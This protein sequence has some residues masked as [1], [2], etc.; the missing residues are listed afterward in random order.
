VPDGEVAVTPGA[1]PI[2]QDGET[3]REECEGRGAGEVQGYRGTGEDGG[4]GPGAIMSGGGGVMCGRVAVG[5]EEEVDGREER[6]VSVV[7]TGDDSGDGS[8]ERLAA[9][10]LGG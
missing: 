9:A 1:A 5:N 2:D 6:A 4:V 7:C 8:G 10:S 3:G